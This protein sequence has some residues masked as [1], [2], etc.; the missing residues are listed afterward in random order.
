MLQENKSY[1]LVKVQMHE[2][3]SDLHREDSVAR[4][5]GLI[6]YLTIIDL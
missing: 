6:S 2:M 3:I 5:T 4:D 1:M